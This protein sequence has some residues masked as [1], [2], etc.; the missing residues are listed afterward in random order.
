VPATI[1]KKTIMRRGY[2][3]DQ[4]RRQSVKPTIACNLAAVSAA[5]GRKTLVIDL[6]VQGI[7]PIICWGI[8]SPILMRPLPIFSRKF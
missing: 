3:F 2:I 8:K 5:E 1:A 7:H 6:D 4:R